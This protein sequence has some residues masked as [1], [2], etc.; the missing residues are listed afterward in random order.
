MGAS[1]WIIDSE[2][3]VV[4]HIVS[5]LSWRP[6]NIV[7]EGFCIHMGTPLPKLLMTWLKSIMMIVSLV[8]CRMPSVRFGGAES[9]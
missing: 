4:A 7:A 5:A 9:E 8:C 1:V 2:V 3:S 6:P